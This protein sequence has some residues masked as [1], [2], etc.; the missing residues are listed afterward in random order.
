MK[1]SELL[2]LLKKHG[3]KLVRNGSR[4]DIFYS[5]LTDAEFPVWRHGKDIPKGTAAEILKQAGIQ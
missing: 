4:H 3:C 1:R 2:K 5:P